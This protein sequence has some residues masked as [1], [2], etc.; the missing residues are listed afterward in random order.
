MK[1]TYR[2]GYGRD[3][4]EISGVQRGSCK[5]RGYRRDYVSFHGYTRDF[6][7][8]ERLWEIYSANHMCNENLKKYCRI[9]DTTD[10][11]AVLGFLIQHLT[12]R[13]I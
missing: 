3:Q 13:L 11:S 6:L 1:E 4:S 5:I 7:N 9:K 8:V 12:V 2:E 10:L